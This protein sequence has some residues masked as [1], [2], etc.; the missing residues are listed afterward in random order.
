MVERK[1]YFR[2]LLMIEQ[3]LFCSAP[4]SVNWMEKMSFIHSFPIN[5]IK[6]YFIWPSYSE[7][8]SEKWK[9]TLKL[10]SRIERMAFVPIQNRPIAELEWMSFSLFLMKVYSVHFH[11]SDG[12]SKYNVRIKQTLLKS[13]DFRYFLIVS[14]SSGFSCW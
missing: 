1:C 3:I 4:K 9:W 13:S 8:P 2:K 11:F 10:L 14:F 5:K 7:R 6:V 12:H